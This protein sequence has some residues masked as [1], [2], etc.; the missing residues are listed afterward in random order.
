MIRNPFIPASIASSPEDFFGRS[1]ELG[2]L[3]RNLMIGSVA[4]Q[5]SIGIGKSSLLSR[6][7]LLMEGFESSHTCVS[8]YATAHSDIQ[9]IDDAARILVESLTDVD[10]I[11]STIS[12]KFPKIFEIKSTQLI[13]NF[14]EGRHLSILNK[15]LEKQYVDQ[16]LKDKDLLIVAID[17]VDKAP[18]PFAKLIR[19]VQTHLQQNGIDKVRFC[20]A[21]VHPYFQLMVNEDPGINRFFYKNVMLYPMKHD[22]TLT[23]L[24]TK[25]DVYRESV[26]EESSKATEIDHKTVERMAAISGG[27]PHIAQLL[28][29]HI[30]ENERDNPDNIIDTK[31]LYNSL[32]KICYEDRE[33]VYNH[34]IHFLELN[35]KF[36]LFKELLSIAREGFPTRIDRSDALSIASVDDLHWFALN[37]YFLT[38]EDNDYGLID[39]FIRVRI[40]FD[41]AEEESAA[42]ERRMLES[43]AI[44]TP[45][46]YIESEHEFSEEFEEDSVGDPMYL[47][48]SEYPEEDDIE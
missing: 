37:N 4:I 42:I 23:L 43:E 30:I 36:I 18:V 26:F 6:I 19:S 14:S 40:M 3:E 21:G 35:N 7:R 32:W 13:R 46:T 28:G 44:N 1:I 16:Y 8:F 41:E 25:L 48:Y 9:T 38:L 45:K 33:Y 10:E 11:N 17:E 5:G 34:S 24:A 27:H 20:L 31:D 15:L 12:L 29:S 22:E 39:E 2:I 47:E